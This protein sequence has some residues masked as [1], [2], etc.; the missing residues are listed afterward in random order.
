MRPR[1]AMSAFVMLAILI[2]SSMGYIGLVP[3]R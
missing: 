2:A 3:A 1:K